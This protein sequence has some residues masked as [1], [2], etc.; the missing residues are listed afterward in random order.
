MNISTAFI[1]LSIIY[2]ICILTIFRIKG[3]INSNQLR[4]YEHLLILNL[5]GLILELASTYS[6][7]VLGLGHHLTNISNRLYLVYL[8]TFVMHFIDYVYSFTT[9]EENYNIKKKRI[10][11]IMWC[12]FIIY[13]IILFILPIELH[14]GQY[15][16]SSGAAVN[17]VYVIATLGIMLCILMI[18]INLK[19]VKQV[20]CFFIGLVFF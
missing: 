16:Y 7:V 11:T 6:I 3:H 1:L 18:L 9:S 14:R 2:N 13:T 17:F 5:L 8:I 20:L 19:N 10:I 15:I 4:I 12:I